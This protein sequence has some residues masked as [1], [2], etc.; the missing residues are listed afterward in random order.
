ML[1]FQPM[2]WTCVLSMAA[3]SMIVTVHVSNAPKHWRD[4]VFGEKNRTPF[5]NFINVA[6]GGVVTQAP[7]RNFPR[8]ILLIWMLSCMVLRNSYQSALFS[9]IQSQKSAVEI[10]SLEKLLRYNYTIYSSGQI[11]RLLEFG[12]PLISK[13]LVFF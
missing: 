8:M 3:V 12:S 4:F 2:L 5:L 7:V 1:P 13:K 10:N 9:S 11:L 6:L